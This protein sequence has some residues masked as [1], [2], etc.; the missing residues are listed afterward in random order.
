[1][2][3]WKIEVDRFCR[4]YLQLEPNIDFPQDAYIRL[5]DAQNAIYTNLFA[6]GAIEFAPT[7]RYQLRVLKQLVSR[8][9]TSIEDWEEHVSVVACN[10]Q[11][12]LPSV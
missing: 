2:H 12:I 5:A 1:M 7:K 3:P 10:R 8:I 6:D 11:R 4:Q 9:E